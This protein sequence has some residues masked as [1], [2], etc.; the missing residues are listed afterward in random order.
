MES[1]M[2]HIGYMAAGAA[3][4]FLVIGVTQAAFAG[5]SLQDKLQRLDA[6]YLNQI[7]IINRADEVIGKQYDIKMRAEQTLKSTTIDLANVKVQLEME[8]EEP[9]MGEVSRLSQKAADNASQLGL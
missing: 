6:D 2:T 1:K 8:K 7:E 4:F 3:T 9:N 5:E